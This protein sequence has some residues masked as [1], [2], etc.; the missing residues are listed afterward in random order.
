MGKRQ[1]TAS[2]LLD[3]TGYMKNKWISEGTAVEFT[4]YNKVEVTREE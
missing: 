4:I 2:T 3:P 1:D